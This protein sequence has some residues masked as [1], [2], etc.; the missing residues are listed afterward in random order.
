MAIAESELIINPDGSIYHLNLM[1]GDLA[2]TII[3]VGD[4]DRVAKV[5]KYF[6]RIVLKKHKRE[7]A[8]HTGYIGDK[9]LSVISTGIGTDNIDIV[10]TEIDAL[11]NIDFKTRT[12]TDKLTKL[13]FIRIGT[14][15][16]LQDDIPLDS[17]LIS[18][19]A[20]GID[21]LN[22]FYTIPENYKNKILDEALKNQLQLE[23]N[24]Y[25]VLADEALVKSFANTTGFHQGTTFTSIGFFAPQGRNVRS[26]VHHVDFIDQI[27]KLRWDNGKRI[28][29][30]EM[31]TSAMYLFAANL[32]HRAISL[33]AL[34]ANRQKG[35]FSKDPKKIVKKLIVKSLEVIATL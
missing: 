10:F 25:S 12:I 35:Q 23:L 28:T 5:S 19:C 20:I 14:S 22:S 2:E 29:N 21:N 3:T 32:G 4:Q 16:C 9:K 31:E 1:P 33:N 17:L 24:S 26:T 8:C 11:F 18:E 34:I 27:D 30:L 15:G 13:T 7:F 6:D